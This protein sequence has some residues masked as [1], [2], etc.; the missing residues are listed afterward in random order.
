MGD[1]PVLYET[2]FS[3]NDRNRLSALNSLSKRFDE[4]LGSKDRREIKEEFLALFNRRNKIDEN[5][6]KEKA[7]ETQKTRDARKEMA[8]KRSR[9][10][11]AVD[12]RTK[13]PQGNLTD[14]TFRLRQSLKQKQMKSI[15]DL[16]KKIAQK[17]D[18]NRRKKEEAR[19]TREKSQEE[20]PRTSRAADQVPVG[21]SRPEKA[22]DSSFGS[23]RRG[24][25]I[26]IAAGVIGGG[27]AIAAILAGVAFSRSTPADAPPGE[28]PQEQSGW[29]AATP[30]LVVVASVLTAAAV[31]MLILYLMNRNIV[32]EPNMWAKQWLASDAPR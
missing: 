1:D 29:D 20:A 7:G 2:K 12:E 16:A 4:H 25:S 14:D 26:A 22:K 21:P 19:K 13:I 8:S 10:M 24:R 9:F 27:A 32:V 17:A 11:N 28:A 15:F 5:F 18:D 6:F 23:A 30:I 31:A 3:I